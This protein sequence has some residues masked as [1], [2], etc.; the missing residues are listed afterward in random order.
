MAQTS[1]PTLEIIDAATGRLLV[2]Q[3]LPKGFLPQV[4]L[5]GSI[6]EVLERPDGEIVVVLHHVQLSCPNGGEG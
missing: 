6:V 4:L 5:N 2:Q 1:D 3:P